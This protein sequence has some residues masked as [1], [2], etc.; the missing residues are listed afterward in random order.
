[1]NRT[2]SSLALIAAAGASLAFSSIAEASSVDLQFQGSGLRTNMTIN[3]SGVHGLVS[4]AVAAGQLRYE[5]TGVS[6][7]MSKHLSVGEQIRVFC[8]DI[9]EMATSGTA[10]IVGVADVPVVYNQSNTAMG[11]QR[12]KLV[13]VLY[14]LRHSDST[15]SN[16][17]AAAFQVALWEIVHED[18]FNAVA[19]DFTDTNLSVDDGSFVVTGN[20]SVRALA[21]SW[22]EEAWAAWQSGD[23]GASMVAGAATGFQDVLFMIP[24][25]GPGAMAMAGLLGLGAVRR[26]R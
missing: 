16:R 25:P 11:E 15:L 14:G 26:R 10:A 20:S 22:V 12:A 3:Y 17:R 8:T 5:V 2:R 21:Q 23:T 1:M 18:N 9:F 19:G 24:L 4:Q 6:G 13:R 7:F